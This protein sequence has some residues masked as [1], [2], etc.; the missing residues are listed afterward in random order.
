MPGE[1]FRDDAWQ[2]RIAARFLDP[3]YE[4]FRWRV[5]RYPG[6]HDQQRR[7]VDF[8]LT[9]GC[10]QNRVD[11]KII[12]GRRD[13]RPATKISY[14]T[15]S[16]TTPEAER[17]GWGARGET[18]DSTVLLVCFADTP[19]LDAQ[20]WTRVKS[21]DCLWVPFQPLRTW[22]W[23]MDGEQRWE[24]KHNE[25]RNGSISHKVPIREILAEFPEAA[26]F[27]A[28]AAVLDSFNKLKQRRLELDAALQAL[29]DQLPPPFEWLP[30]SLMDEILARRI[31]A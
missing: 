7:H 15:M 20:S 27:T 6:N 21:L 9:R 4:L 18:N 12:R 22:F 16:C 17:L 26:R 5:H 11:E 14:E 31:A 3:M 29:E 24:R 8:L 2:T 13:G 28:S 1:F 10:K 23:R 25:Q 30:D 19:D